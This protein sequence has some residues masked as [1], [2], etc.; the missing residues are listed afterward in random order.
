MKA[1]GGPAFLALALVAGCV[2]T[3]E[4]AGVTLDEYGQA[5]RFTAAVKAGEIKLKDSTCPALVSAFQAG[6]KGIPFIPIRGL[7]GSDLLQNRPDYRVI[8]NPMAGTGDPI[9]LLPAIT[10]DIALFHAPLA[11]RH[12]NVWIG[13]ARECMTMA[14][15]ARRTLVK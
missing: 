14:H 13:K 8:D 5:G 10:P 9:V 11:D 4:S 12:G 15:A 2:A 7:L 3:M 1:R 6:E